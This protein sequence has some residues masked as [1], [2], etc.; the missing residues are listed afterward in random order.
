CGKVSF[1]KGT[2]PRAVTVRAFPTAEPP[3]PFLGEDVESKSDGSFCFDWIEPGKFMI[4]A[5]ETEP[6]RSNVRYVGYYPGVLPRS[7]ATPIELKRGAGIVRADFALVRQPLFTVRGYL[8]G[9]PDSMVEATQVFLMSDQLDAFYYVE[10]PALGPHGT[11]EVRDVPPG[12]YTA[13]AMREND[14]EE[15]TTFVSTVS[16]VEIRGNVEDLKLEFVPAR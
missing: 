7:Q 4:G 10:P 3:F 8:R 13:F 9:V 2:E 6:R 16:A 12:H 11:F 15:S 5:S 1:P 14:E